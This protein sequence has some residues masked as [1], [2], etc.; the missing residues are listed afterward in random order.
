VGVAAGN[1]NADAL[2]DLVTADLDGGTVSVIAHT[3]PQPGVSVL[4][5]APAATN[6]TS[7]FS[8][9]V[10]VQPS[11]TVNWTVD[12]TGDAGAT[13]SAPSAG[14]CGSVLQCTGSLTASGPVSITVTGGAD[15][16][17]MLTVTATDTVTTDSD[18]ASLTVD[19]TPPADPV[20]TT[21]GGADFHVISQAVFIQGTT[22]ADTAKIQVQTA[23]GGPFT[24]VSGYTAGSTTWQFSGLIDL[25]TTIPF[26]FQAV[27]AV[28]NVSQP[29]CVN[30]TR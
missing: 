28:G 14:T 24:D 8:F 20:I 5:L 23:S 17:A 2:P 22:A 26:C 4:R 10:I 7:L 3:L 21:N 11:T 15:T 25:G 16:V 29:D 19:K 9:W 30:V 27:D 6:T 12:L 1:L 18:S 13:M